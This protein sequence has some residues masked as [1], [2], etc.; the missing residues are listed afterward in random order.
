M[1]ARLSVHLPFTLCIPDGVAFQ[2]VPYDLDGCVVV[3]M[4]P[5]RTGLS[6]PLDRPRVITV[7]DAPAFEADVLVID[8]YKEEFD[9]RVTEEAVPPN[10]E[11]SIDTLQV[12]THSL[13]RRL[14]YVTQGAMLKPVDLRKQ[15]FTV[16]YL[17]E[18]DSGLPR[19]EGRVR[20][21]G[22]AN[23][24]FRFALC[25]PEIWVAAQ[26]LGPTFQAPIWDELLLDAEDALPYVGSA[27]VLGAVALERFITETLDQ[28]ATAAV[29]PPALW[30]WLMTQPDPYKLPSVTDM[31]DDLLE[32]FTG[33]S[34]QREDA[35]LWQGMTSLKN[36]RNNFVHRGIPSI[37]K[38]GPPLSA[39][40]ALQ[41]LQQANSVIGKVRGWLPTPQP[42]PPFSVGRRLQFRVPLTDSPAPPAPT[43]AATLAP[44]PAPGDQPTGPRTGRKK[45]K[46]VRTRKRTATKGKK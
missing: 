30:T 29:K 20:R 45:A 5:Q 8:F 3:D 22:G 35:A 11:P 6:S 44:A 26:Q 27:V 28:L 39:S 18:D 43:P 36:A 40:E 24:S 41:L 7:D 21:R 37:G 14:R 38:N 16:Q 9:R 15:H 17:N 32:V 10:W 31:F 42:W 1:K 23:F 13:V 34:L 19:Q 12:A 2:S 33:H 25:T 4:P 46:P